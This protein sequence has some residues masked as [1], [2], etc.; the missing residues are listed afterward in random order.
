MALT[1]AHLLLP[2]Q[3]FRTLG[4]TFR[5]VNVWAH[6]VEAVVVEGVY[7]LSR[8]GQTAYIPTG[9]PRASLRVEVLEA[10][11]SEGAAP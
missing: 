1:E 8:P 3:R 7:R 4:T 6:A 9:G 5:A 10:P 2:G 11:R